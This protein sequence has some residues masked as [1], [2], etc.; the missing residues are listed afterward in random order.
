MLSYPD[1]CDVIKKFPSELQKMK[2][3]IIKNSY[4][5]CVLIDQV[6]DLKNS[7][8]LTA[9][10]VTTIME[11][12]DLLVII[13]ANSLVNTPLLARDMWRAEC[14]V[15]HIKI[16]KNLRSQLMNTNEL[17]AALEKEMCRHSL[18]LASSI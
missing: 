5:P 11:A 1:V 15:Y 6:N 10:D 14:E 4:V 12:E 7:L 9:K 2:C 8:S 18:C 17:R 13:R 3:D 16:V